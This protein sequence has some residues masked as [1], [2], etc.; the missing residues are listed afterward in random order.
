MAPRVVHLDI[1]GQRYAVRSELDAQYIAE[2]A[3][4]LDDRM[5][6]A[7]REI[8]TADPLR[9]AIVAA[10]NLTDE[11]FRARAEAGGLEG[12]VLARTAEI[13]RLLDSVLTEARVQAV[14]E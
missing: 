2:L 10:L 1:H 6:A 14:N 13:E 11:L 12:R 7:A 5:R 4:Y 9:I 8:S 3:S